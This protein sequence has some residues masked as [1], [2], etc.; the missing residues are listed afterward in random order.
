MSG[1]IEDISVDLMLVGLLASTKKNEY[2]M[3]LFDA[4]SNHNGAEALVCG[5]SE[6]SLRGYISGIMTALR[7]FDV[8][9]AIEHFHK[10]VGSLEEATAS[11]LEHNFRRE[12]EHYSDTGEE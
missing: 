7:A 12:V 9:D 10:Y 11:T 3:R 8:E 2:G 4:I 6:E 1:K 5:M